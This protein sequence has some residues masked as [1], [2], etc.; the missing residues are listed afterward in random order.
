[1]PEISRFLGMVVRMHW[2]DHP[3]PHLHVDYGG[4]QAVVRIDTLDVMRGRLP[5]RARALLAEWA[6]LHRQELRD[7]WQRAERGDPLL[8]IAPLE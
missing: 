8:P 6:L 7:N 1:M 3:P 4:E 5:V 2:D